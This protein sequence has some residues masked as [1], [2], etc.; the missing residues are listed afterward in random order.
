[1]LPRTLLTVVALAALSL[2]AGAGGDGPA[3]L[4][5]ADSFAMVA[6]RLQLLKNGAVLAE[7]APAL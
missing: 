4:E 2:P 5:A 6:D 3:A 7:L 1:M